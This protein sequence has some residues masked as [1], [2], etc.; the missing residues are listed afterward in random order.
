MRIAACA[1]IVAAVL[2]ASPHADAR[3]WADVSL[4]GLNV[5]GQGSGALFDL[6]VFGTDIP[7]GTSFTE[8][9]PYTITLHADGAPAPR[10]WDACLPMEPLDCGPAWTGAELVEFEF[11]TAR[12]REVS[13]FTDYD[14]SGMPPSLAVEADGTVTYRGT[15]SI[16]ETVAP[17]GS[18]FSN[19]DYLVVWVATWI[20]SNDAV[21]AVPEPAGTASML[22]GLG[23]LAAAAL[24]CRGR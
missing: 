4:A 18:Y 8:D 24:A 13:P 3:A 21:S 6:F 22:L 23:L 11:G 14:I 1:T 9:F 20:D 16:T 10:S 19:T 15:L 5:S 17:F 2:S 12:P 7:G